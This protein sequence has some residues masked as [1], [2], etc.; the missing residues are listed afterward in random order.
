RAEPRVRGEKRAIDP[1]VEHVHA[2][3]AGADRDDVPDRAVA[4]R[5]PVP[6]RTDVVGRADYFQHVFEFSGVADDRP[7][8]GDQYFQRGAASMGRLNYILRAKT[9]I[10][11]RDATLPA[12]GQPAGNIEFRNLSFAYPTRLSGNGAPAANGHEPKPVLRNINLTIPAGSTLAVVGP[13][14]SGKTTLA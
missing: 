12:E 2:V 10:D 6:V 9:Q 14:G 13:T 4:G 8:V 1:D 11:D 3:A 5:L 7:R